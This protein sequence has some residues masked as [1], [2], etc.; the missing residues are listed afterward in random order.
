MGPSETSRLGMC[1]LAGAQAQV[2]LPSLAMRGPHASQAKP[3]Q[4]MPSQ[5]KPSQL[6]RPC[7]A[8][9]GEASPGQPARQ[10]ASQETNHPANLTPSRRK[11]GG[12]RASEFPRLNSGEHKPNPAQASPTLSVQTDR[13]S[14][15]ANEPAEERASGR[16]NQ[17]RNEPTQSTNQPTPTKPT[18]RPTPRTTPRPT[19]RPT[20]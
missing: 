3:G 11:S 18:T 12:G 13:T 8:M 1:D 15:R 2:Q 19:P 17:P 5:A 14:E 20:P 6:A 7:R 16:T 10:P 4:A 9:P